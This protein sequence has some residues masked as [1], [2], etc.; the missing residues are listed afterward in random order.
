MNKQEAIK[1]IDRTLSLPRSIGGY[2][3]DYEDGLR[4]AKDIIN[5]IDE[6]EKVKLTK[7]QEDY[8]LSF[9]DI[10]NKESE[11]RT[12]ALYYIVRVG[13]GYLFTTAPSA[14]SDKIPLNGDYYK[15]LS[16]N[17]DFDDL[18]TL[19]IKALVNGYEVEK[20]KLYTAKLKIIV[21]GDNNY[22]NKHSDTGRF[23]LSNLYTA[24][25]AYQTSFTLPELEQLNVWDNPVF[26]IE[27]VSNE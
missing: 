9:G 19:L 17:L 6:P 15:K 27:E 23:T 5:Q 3:Y 26:E 14:G 2:P 10:K 24:S 12:V 20:E 25:G 8:L 22:L 11:D 4:Y 21:N 18:K 7:A 16:G 1:K 13:W